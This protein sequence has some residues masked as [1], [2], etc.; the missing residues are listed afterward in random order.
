MTTGNGSPPRRPGG[1]PPAGRGA[2]SGAV[3]KR[4]PRFWM[5]RF[6][7]FA[8]LL[9]FIAVGYG[10]YLF[11]DANKAIKE[12]SYGTSSEVGSIGSSPFGMLVMGVDTR[13]EGGLL[14]TDVLM[15]AAFNPKTKSAVVVSIPRDSRIEVKGYKT[16]KVNSYYSAFLR[17]AKSE[18]KGVS[19]ENAEHAAAKGMKDAI[20]RFLGIPIAYS[21]NV[22]F[23]GFADVVDALGGVNVNVDMDM[24]YDDHAGQPGGTS[25]HLRKGEQ[26][27]GGEDALGFVRYRKSNDGKNMSSD[28]ER[29]ERQE[30]VVGAITD[31][32]MSVPGLLRLGNVFGAVGGNVKTDMPA[33]D[34]REMMRVYF[35]ISKEDIAFIPLT[36][37]WRSP[38]VYLDEAVVAKASKALQSKLDE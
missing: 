12:M 32:M 22:N 33:S 6:M 23:Q 34:I 2:R 5:R 25:I 36:G 26:K 31:R 15:A 16:R 35:G 1:S 9:V 21:A 17:N 19:Q 3:K 4:K 8:S 24:D 29:N 10:V 7:L 30:Q 18:G 20:G 13:G 38:Y 14:N 27:L 37:E 11:M 28:F